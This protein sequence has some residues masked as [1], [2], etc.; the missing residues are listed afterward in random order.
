MPRV[1]VSW[2]RLVRLAVVPAGLAIAV[3]GF[4][5]ARGPGSVTTYAGRSW[6]ATGLTVAAGLT[7]VLAGLLAWYTSRPGPAGDLA[8]LAG[9]VW[10]APVWVGWEF[11]PMIVRSLA[12]LVAGFVFALLF[13][14]VLAFPG[15]P[16]P[17]AGIRALVWA[18][19]L[20]AALAALGLALFRPPPATQPAGPTAATT[21]S[22]SARCRPSRKPSR[23]RTDGS[24]PRRRRCCWWWC[25]PGG[26]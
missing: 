8:L 3:G 13:H 16:P 1:S 10:F 20:E 23:P 15:G 22:S 6:L 25:A 4:L 21:C 9:L 2:A 7:L 26:C 18:V 19:Y 14:L 5:I 17:S 24:P 11:G 12:M